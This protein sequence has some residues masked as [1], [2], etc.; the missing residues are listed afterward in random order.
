M[1]SSVGELRERS[2]GSRYVSLDGL[3]GVAAFTVMFHH[4][5][6]MYDLPRPWYLTPLLAGEQAVLLFFV[7]SGFVLSLPFWNKGTLGSYKSYLARR[8]FRIYVPLFFARIVALIGDYFWGR[9]HLPLGGWYYMTWQD[10]VTPRFAFVQLLFGTSA[11]L[12]TAFWSLRYELVISILF[13]ALLFLL[14]RLKLA[15]SLVLMVALYAVGAGL[16][17]FVHGDFFLYQETMRFGSMFVL[18]ALLARQREQLKNALNRS[19]MAA[20]S[21]LLV[22]ALLLFWGTF[23]HYLKPPTLAFVQEPLLVLGSAGLIVLCLSM[24]QF[25]KFFEMRVP[26]YLGRISYS[27]Y[28]LHGTVLFALT[29]LLY[30]KLNLL[31][32]FVP[33]VL[34]SFGMAHVFCRVIEEPALRLGKRVGARLT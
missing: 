9:G 29:N 20:K 17:L 4:F 5:F 13:P 6:F 15:G 22:V 33:Y 2:T 34:L 31:E 26:E 1:T 32:I 12:N 23:D 14:Y 10:K 7:L 25:R 28:L 21:S 24:S 27:L 8:F 30:G 19:G 16:H 3:R 11:H 18:G